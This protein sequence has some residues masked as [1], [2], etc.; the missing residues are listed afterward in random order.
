MEICDEK[1]D[2]LIVDDNPDQLLAL[3]SIVSEL[4]NPVKARSGKEALSKLLKK[5]F[6]LILLD[7]HM[8]IM[9]G[10]ETAALIR[11]RPRSENTPIIFVTAIS[12]TDE[13]VATGYGLGAVDYIF[14]PV[15]PSILKAKVKV[16]IDLFKMN[17]E[18]R[19][20]THELQSRFQEIENLNRD[21]AK[22]NE[23][24]L[25]FAYTASHD[26][27]EPL[28][29]VIS[30]LQMFEQRQKGKID[31]NSDQLIQFA[32][33]GATKMRRLIKDL[34]TYS[35]I[36]TQGDSFEMVD[37]KQI[38][39]QTLINLTNLIQ[40]KHTQIT[41][42]E[43]PMVLADPTQLLQVFQNLIGNA[44]K[45]ASAESSKVHVLAEKDTTEW[46][47][48]VRDNGIGIPKEYFEKIFLIF[49]QLSKDTPFVGTGIGLAIVKK[50][51]ERHRGR[52]WV[53]S[54]VGLGSTFYFSIPN[55]SVA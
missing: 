42:G 14:A 4:A 51:I 26:L 48:S 32:V 2:V 5:D 6:P 33:N 37:T 41:C 8:P 44:V 50:I 40:Q 19:L 49:Q 18:L 39:D 10:F 17:R 29:T 35:R 34:L 21:L 36:S 9:D 30:A 13:F 46:V 47:F 54:E 7:V 11:Q 52:V 28:R 16:F 45:F 31:E 27:Q 25:S 1:I 12:R 38:F 22:S 24:L 23:D 53:E 15:I 55:G 3:E 43:L 20:Q